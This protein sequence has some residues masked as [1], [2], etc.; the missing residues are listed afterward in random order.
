MVVDFVHGVV[1]VWYR[2]VNAEHMC[3]IIKIRIYP[4]LC[5]YI[6]LLLWGSIFEVALDLLFLV[7]LVVVRFVE[8]DGVPDLICMRSKNCGS[9]VCWHPLHSKLSAAPHEH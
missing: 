5:T 2:V 6:G 9:S 7:A 4:K 1:R 3:I 8:A